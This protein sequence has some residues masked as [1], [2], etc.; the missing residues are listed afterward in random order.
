MRK[1]FC[2]NPVPYRATEPGESAE[3]LLQRSFAD[4]EH[5]KSQRDHPSKVDSSVFG[6]SLSLFLFSSNPDISISVTVDGEEEDEEEEG[7]EG[8]DGGTKEG[9]NV[10]SGSS[11]AQRRSRCVRQASLQVT[12]PLSHPQSPICCSSGTHPV[13]S[14][15]NFWLCNLFKSVQ[16]NL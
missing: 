10:A 9:G 11:A 16:G 3:S 1:I 2:R 4:V 5:G 12:H 15:L 6:K 7:G 14:T 13:I 8:D